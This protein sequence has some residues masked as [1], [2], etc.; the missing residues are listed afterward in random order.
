M[1]I[2]VVKTIQEKITGLMMAGGAPAVSR[3]TPWLIL[4]LGLA[5]TSAFAQANDNF[6]N[7]AIITG[8]TGTTNG[9]N[10][11]AT[12]EQPCETNHV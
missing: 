4:V 11:G 6:A 10:V 12:L 5:A 9:S 7:A 8:A 1:K 3:F 2:K